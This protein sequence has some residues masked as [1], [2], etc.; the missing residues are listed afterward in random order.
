MSP[1]HRYS[2][3]AI[4]PTAAEIAL[5]ID[6]EMV[7]LLGHQLR[8]RSRPW[9]SCGA[10]TA[11]G[12][13]HPS[14]TN[15]FL[16]PWCSRLID[17]MQAYS[18]VRQENS[19]VQVRRHHGSRGEARRRVIHVNRKML[20]CADDVSTPRF[21]I[22]HFAFCIF[23]DASGGDCMS[24]GKDLTIDGH[25]VPRFFYGT[26]WKEERTQPLTE[27]AVAQGFRASTPPISGGT[28]MRRAWA[29]PWPPWSSAAW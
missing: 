11:A 12:P 2:R 20:N 8:R 27:M 29:R 9:S 21:R 3:S 24:S 25:P 22:Y 26:A 10:A 5:R 7:Q 15:D 4:R 23:R 28:I 6:A 19:I 16:T 14:A 17:A 13:R 18:R 1:W